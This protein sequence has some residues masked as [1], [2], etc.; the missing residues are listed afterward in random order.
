MEIIKRYRSFLIVVLIVITGI[1]FFFYQLYQKDIKVL[2]DF[3]VSYKKFD[4][5][6][7]DFS[8][9]LTDSSENKAEDAIRELDTK[10]TF[11]ISSLIKNEKKV[12]V[13]VREISNLSKREFDSLKSYREAVQ[14]KNADLERFAKEYADLTV[15]RRS[16]YFGLVVLGRTG[17]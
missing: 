5:A 6:I 1:F 4:K 10:S 2:A 7:T 12:M 13:Q 9:S 17:E 14:N 8:V 16:A 11:R 3:V 15:K